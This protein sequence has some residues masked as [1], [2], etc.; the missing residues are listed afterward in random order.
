MIE[1]IFNARFEVGNAARSAAQH[2]IASKQLANPRRKR[3]QTRPSAF[4]DSRLSNPDVRGMKQRLRDHESLVRE[5]K[6]LLTGVDLLSRF[7]RSRREKE[8]ETSS[9]PVE[10][11]T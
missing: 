4:A 2:D 1:R 3:L 7:L 11:I 6:H 8:R 9:Y 10:E 5:L